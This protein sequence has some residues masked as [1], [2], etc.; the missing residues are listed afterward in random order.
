M[1]EMNLLAVGRFH[2]S[3]SPLSVLLLCCTFLFFAF[4]AVP[5]FYS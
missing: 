4:G 5:F 2:F 1:L 3:L